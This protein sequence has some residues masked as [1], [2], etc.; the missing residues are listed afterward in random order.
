MHHAGK[1]MH[2]HLAFALT[3]R[4]PNEQKNG[5]KDANGV[6]AWQWSHAGADWIAAAK[7]NL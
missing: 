2:F 5:A 1:S 6:M 4:F 3:D 7:G